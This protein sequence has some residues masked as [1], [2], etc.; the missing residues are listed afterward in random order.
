[1]ILSY[2]SSKLG[3]IFSDCLDS[4]LNTDYPSFE[5]ILVDNASADNAAETAFERYSKNHENLR[6]LKLEKNLGYTGG[7]NSGFQHVSEKAE[8]VAFLNDDV[9]VSSDWLKPLIDA[10]K[11]NQ[12]IGAIGPSGSYIAR[13]STTVNLSNQNLVAFSHSVGYVHGHCLVIRRN[14]FA[15]VGGFNP[16]IFIYGDEI[17]LCERLRSIGFDSYV[18]PR[19]RVRHAQLPLTPERVATKLYWNSRNQILFA[20]QNFPPGALLISF[21]I[22]LLNRAKHIISSAFAKNARACLA[23]VNGSLNGIAQ[24]RKGT[25]PG[26]GRRSFEDP[27]LLP[28]SVDLLHVVLPGRIARQMVDSIIVGK[29]SGKRSN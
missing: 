11:E 19:N 14:A 26:Y 18:V 16:H 29:I 20:F 24:I 7:N 2:N 25:M 23:I 27:S 17:D 12:N 9:I 15:K 5:V 13:G 1:M 6:F 10:S 4:V 3:A 22:I 21:S 28:I 8:F